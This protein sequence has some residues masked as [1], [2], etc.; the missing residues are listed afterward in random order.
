MIIGKPRMIAYNMARTDNGWRLTAYVPPTVPARDRLSVVQW[1]GD[2]QQQVKRAQPE[3]LVRFRS[4]DPCHYEV[5]V[6]P[7]YRSGSQ[8]SNQAQ[9]EKLDTLWHQLSFNYA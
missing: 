2:Y 8:T 6:L 1:L 5:D 4:E 3:W 9:L 7:L